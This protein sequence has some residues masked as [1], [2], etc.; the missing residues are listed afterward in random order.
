MIKLS[1]E[2]S[3][4]FRRCERCGFLHPLTE[5]YYPGDGAICKICIRRYYTPLEERTQ[6]D[7]AEDRRWLKRRKK[8][9]RNV[10]LHGQSDSNIQAQA[11][12]TKAQ[13]F[14]ATFDAEDWEFALMYFDNRCAVCG[15]QRG[16]WHTL[17]MDHWIPLSRGGGFVPGNIVPLC[18][19]DASACNRVKADQLPLDWLLSTRSEKEARAI[20]DR[21]VKFLGI[22]K[23]KGK[24]DNG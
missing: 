6:A 3:S 21:I 24:N 14:E 10:F 12:R 22:A 4:E 11:I 9:S 16:F 19:G 2:S 18:H 7:I 20:E 1:R 17:A 13:G 8:A 15:R 5:A 23:K